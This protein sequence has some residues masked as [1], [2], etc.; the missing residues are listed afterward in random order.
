MN[1]SF[2]GR[3]PRR[4]RFAF[5]QRF[6]VGVRQHHRVLVSASAQRIH[7]TDTPPDVVGGDGYFVA[8]IAGNVDLHSILDAGALPLAAGDG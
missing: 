6:H 4:D 3:T 8:V 5:L 1:V 2:D 7:S